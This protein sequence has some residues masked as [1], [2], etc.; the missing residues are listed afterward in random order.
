[1]DERTQGRTIGGVIDV[2]HQEGR[3]TC[4]DLDS[5]DRRGGEK[6]VSRL[7]L[8]IETMFG[9]VYGDV[10]FGVGEG[11]GEDTHPVRMRWASEDVFASNDI[12]A[13]TTKPG[14]LN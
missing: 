5:E 11:R 1:V 12:D 10:R 7:D 14:F 9:D 2:D 13:N 6:V 4:G 3:R 8:P